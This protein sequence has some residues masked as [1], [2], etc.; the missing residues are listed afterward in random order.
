MD[1][2]R[3]CVGVEL[4]YGR[5]RIDSVARASAGCRRLLSLA[6]HVGLIAAFLGCLTVGSN[7]PAAQTAVPEFDPEADV[8]LDM[9]AGGERPDEH[10][11][12]Q[13]FAQQYDDFD[14]CVSR[15]KGRSARQL[16]GDVAVAVLLNPRGRRPLGV[17]AT[18][19]KPVRKNGGLRE[20]LR[21][22]VA[23]APFPRYDGVPVVAEFSFELD[24]DTVW[25][26]E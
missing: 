7:A 8:E 21:A 24:P 17:N 25:V 19:P 15:A 26:E 14:V 1:V 16:P 11:L 23:A 6:G 12:L 4:G 9:Q 10:L 5:S 22:A 20:C 3:K 13:A 2:S 18:L